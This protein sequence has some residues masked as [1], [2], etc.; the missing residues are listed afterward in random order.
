MGLCYVVFGMLVS[1]LGGRVA[2]RLACLQWSGW[3]VVRGYVVDLS[4][5]SVR[6]VW[7]SLRCAVCL[8]VRR[9]VGVVC[10]YVLGALGRCGWVWFVGSC[11]PFA[12]AWRALRS[13]CASLGLCQVVSGLLVGFGWLRGGLRVVGVGCVLGC[14]VCLAGVVCERVLG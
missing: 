10:L 4:V 3:L 1:G 11:V 9:S 2:L 12:R 14:G 5:V 6:F 13:P 7:L 8:V